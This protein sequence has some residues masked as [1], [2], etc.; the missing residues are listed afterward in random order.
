[1]AIGLMLSSI[2]S[3][4][5]PTQP[6]FVLYGVHCVCVCWLC[7]WAETAG[8]TLK[9]EKALT[10][11]DYKQTA[12]KEASPLFLTQ[13]SLSLGFQTCLSKRKGP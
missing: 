3:K 13:F 1:M 11:P 9:K 10:G 2:T 12:R 4:V 8:G 6:L 7:C 5:R